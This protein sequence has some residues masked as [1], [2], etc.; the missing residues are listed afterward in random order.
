[1]NYVNKIDTRVK[2]STLWIIVMINMIFADI[3]SIMISLVEKET[4]TLDN[5]KIL[6]LI[7]A[8][9][10]QIPILMIYFSRS[11]KYKINRIANIVAALFTI[12][13]VIG[14]GTTAPH[15]ILI[16]GVEIIC[17]ILIIKI[18]WSWKDSEIN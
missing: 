1:M 18:S 9:V 11:L 12:I 17:M 10:T 14:G 7:A 5:V 8:V 2:L 13:Y 16:A 3:L 4:L 15:Y 6:M